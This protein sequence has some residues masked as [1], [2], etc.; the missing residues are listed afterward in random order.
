MTLAN[1]K[2]YKKLSILYANLLSGIHKINHL[3]LHAVTEK[4]DFIMLARTWLNAKDKHHLSEP[5][6]N[7]H[8]LFAVSYIQK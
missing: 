2:L 3:T 7:G 4:P 5:A 1:P 8:D 6:I